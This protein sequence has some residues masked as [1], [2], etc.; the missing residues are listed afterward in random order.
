MTVELLP[1]D[2]HNQRTINQGHPPNWQNPAGGDY[3]LVVIGGG[4]AGLISALVGA[5]N[6][7]RVAMTERWL[8]GGTCVNYG[9][10]PSKALI[11]CARAVYEA[12]RGADFGFGLTAPPQVDF[13]K[14][15][16]RVR[17]IRSMS[18]AG[19]AVQVV[20]GAGVDVY[21]GHTTFIKP[22]A[23]T[24]DDRELRFAKAVIATGSR[25]VAPNIEGLREG[26]FLTNQTVFSLTELPRKLVVLGGGP[27]GCE[28]AQAFHRLGSKVD[29]VHSRSNLLPKDEPE[30]GEVL[31]RRLEN[32]GLRL[33]LEFRAIKAANGRLT[34]RSKT[35]T[36]EIAYDKLLLGIGRKANVEDLGLDA[37][38]IRAKDGGV[39]ADQYLRTSNPAVYAAGDV[40]FPEKYTHAAMAT[41]R[42]CIA[43]ALGGADRPAREL[44]IPHCTY[45]DPE[46][47][48]VGLTPI[49]AA[50]MGVA[51]D[52]HRLELAKVERAFIDGEEEGFAALYTRQGTG[53]I[54]GATLVAAHAGEMIS[55]LTLAITNKLTMQDLAE[56]VHCYPTQAEVFQR[57]ALTFGK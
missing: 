57:I 38:G 49:R 53:E 45:T 15:M 23:V 17:R 4:P 3:D 6:G 14:V 36:R 52:T 31:R 8:T 42:V 44:V 9:C 7:R 11:R 48:S 54:V 13:A 34:V 35:E 16:E 29:L 50:E 37:A 47:A 51:V 26:E 41:A 25:P 21:L 19:D 43:N 1:A 46:I 20:A 5:G 32:E 55:E 2:A 10:T 27:M 39:E 56:T 22:N 40:A 18:S 28:L 30:A 24:V 33:H 12:K